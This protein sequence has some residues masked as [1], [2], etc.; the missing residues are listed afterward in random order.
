MVKAKKIKKPD[1]WDLI[2]DRLIEIIE[3]MKKN[4]LS[5]ISGEFGVEPINH[6]KYR[7]SLPSK[8]RH[9]EVFG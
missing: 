9:K 5:M 2:N 8:Y 3:L 7:I 4:S 1:Y 6:W